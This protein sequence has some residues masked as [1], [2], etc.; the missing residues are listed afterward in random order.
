[1]L[2]DNDLQDYLDGVL[3]DPEKKKAFDDLYKEMGVKGMQ[4]KKD[5]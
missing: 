1:M 4:N 5:F 2:N 3:D